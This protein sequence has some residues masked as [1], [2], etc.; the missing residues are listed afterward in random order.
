MLAQFSTAGVKFRELVVSHAFHSS[1][2]DP[3]LEPFERAAAKV[4]FGAPRL[5]LISNLTGQ[6]TSAVQMAQPAYWRRQIRETVQYS[7]S[8][9]T[10][11]DAGCTVFLEI[12]PNPVLLGLGRSCIEPEG[13]L[14][15][16][17]VRSGRDDWAEMLASLSQLY[18]HG[19]DVDW[20]GFD[21]DYPRRKVSLPTYPFQRERYFVDREIQRPVRAEIPQALHP[22][23]ERLIDSPSLKDIVFETSLGA[24]SH[25]FLNDHRVF[26]RIIFPA[27]GYLES[28]CAAARLG[29][30]G[31]N[32]AVENMVIGEALALDDTE[33]KRFQ[34]VLSRTGDSAASFQVFS[35]GTG[36]EPGESS[37]RLHASGSLRSVTDSDEPIDVDFESLKRDATEVGAETFYADYQRRGLDFGARFRGVLQVWGHPGKALG[38]IEPP[39]AMDGEPVEYGLHPALLDACLQ[40]VAGAVRGANEEQEETSLF[41]PLGVESFRLFAPVE[42][43][44]W[45]VATVD[46]GAEGHRETIKAQVQVADQQGRRGRGTTRNVLQTGGPGDA[47]TC[48]PEKQRTLALRNCLDTPG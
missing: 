37:W 25:R 29:L 28:V 32:W 18:A 26:G 6:V 31:G 36:E 43:K 20:A 15:L 1:L 21:R 24:A 10:L 22:L 33:T 13:A 44:L 30:A 42:G 11:A 3:M 17:S 8:V 4:S 23:A 2:M 48:D 46:V 34:V 12:G 9:Q 16:A 47:G 38:L 7:A 27:T 14:W 19:V 45:S 5:R 40:V 39:I 35:T 41:M